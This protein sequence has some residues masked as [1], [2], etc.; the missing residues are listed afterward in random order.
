MCGRV[1]CA[2]LWALCGLRLRAARAAVVRRQ[3]REDEKDTRGRGR[4]C[5]WPKAGRAP[6]EQ[7]EG[8]GKARRPGTRGTQEGSTGGQ[9]WDRQ[10]HQRKRARQRPLGPSGPIGAAGGVGRASTPGHRRGTVSARRGEA[11]ALRRAQQQRHERGRL[12]QQQPPFHSSSPPSKAAAPLPQ[13]QQRHER[14]RLEIGSRGCLAV[15]G[16]AAYVVSGSAVAR[17]A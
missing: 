5:S 9:S 4:S 11:A 8:K 7:G 15:Q 1:R 10:G 17:G 2:G 6:R 14:G 3:M 13:Q 12:P 16:G